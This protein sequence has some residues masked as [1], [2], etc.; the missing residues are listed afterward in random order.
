V[1]DFVPLPG[2]PGPGEEPY[3]LPFHPLELGEEALR[4]LFGFIIEGRRELGDVDP[5]EVALHGFDLVDPGGPT[6][7]EREAEKDARIA[8]MGPPRMF[9][10]QDGVLVEI[11]SL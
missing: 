1:F 11:D 4:A 7:E 9:R 10:M 5:D 2:H 6:F 8:Q 3:P